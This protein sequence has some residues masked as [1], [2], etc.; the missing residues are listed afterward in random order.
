[1]YCVLPPRRL[2]RRCAHTS[3]L[4]PFGGVVSLSLQLYYNLW[5]AAASRTTGD[6]VCV[7]SNKYTQAII[8]NHLSQFTLN[9][10][11]LII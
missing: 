7:S 2:A 4:G 1:M 10:K 9:L 6:T 8:I 5:C 11:E 3:Y